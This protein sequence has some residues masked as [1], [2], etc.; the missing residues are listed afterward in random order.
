MARQTC[1][2]DGCTG[3]GLS[4]PARKLQSSATACARPL[5]SALHV[6]ICPATQSSIHLSVHLSSCPFFH[7][8]ISPSFPLRSMTRCDPAVYWGLREARAWRDERAMFPPW[9]GSKGGSS[10]MLQR[11]GPKCCGISR[12]GTRK[13][14]QSHLTLRGVS[15]EGRELSPHPTEKGWTLE[16]PRSHCEGADAEDGGRNC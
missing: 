6:P 1:A 3:S 16:W 5:P 2:R 14:A 11:V 15:S 13:R 9:S 7:S 12:G 10:R 8:L 4:G